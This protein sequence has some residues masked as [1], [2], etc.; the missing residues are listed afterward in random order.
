MDILRNKLNSRPPFNIPVDTKTNILEAS[1][2]LGRENR[3]KL[4]YHMRLQ[5]RL[6]K[7]LWHTK[8]SPEV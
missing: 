3:E 4:K 8:Q 2:C 6:H 1:L 5:P 7:E